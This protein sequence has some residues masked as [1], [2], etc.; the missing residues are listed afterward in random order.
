MM[1]EVFAWF[2]IAMII[3]SIVWYSVFLFLVGFKGGREIIKMTQ[4]LMQQTENGNNHARQGL[5]DGPDRQNM[6]NP[7]Q[8]P[9][10]NG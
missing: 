3:F 10:S 5:Q 1:D 9:T 6:H 2:W 7:S 4:N 8:K